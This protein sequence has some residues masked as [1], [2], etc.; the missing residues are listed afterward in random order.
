M[1]TIKQIMKF[2]IPHDE[3]ELIFSMYGKNSEPVLKKQITADGL[4]MATMPETVS[5]IYDAFSSGGVDK[6]SISYATFII[7]QFQDSRFITATN[8]L[9]ISNEKIKVFPNNGLI[10]IPEDLE[11]NR[12]KLS[13]L[14]LDTLLH[15]LKKH[16]MFVRSVDQKYQTG[17]LNSISKLANNKYAKALVGE[18]GLL[19]LVHLQF[20]NK[21]SQCYLGSVSNDLSFPK[22]TGSNISFER[23]DGRYRLKL[24]GDIWQSQGYAFGVY[25]GDKK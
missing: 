24:S 3:G 20:D 9:W 6:N 4:R 22:I 13:G 17:F 21:H 1:K 11:N 2:S 23:V 14:G 25:D 7:D 18:A 16:N 19:K 12:N 10:S 5:I 15:V 8:T